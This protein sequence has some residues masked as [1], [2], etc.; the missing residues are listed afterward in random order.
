MS[1]DSML[2]TLM[3]IKEHVANIVVAESSFEC[4]ESSQKIVGDIYMIMQPRGSSEPMN[5]NLTQE[6]CLT[7]KSIFL[8]LLQALR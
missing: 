7:V 3:E 1:N 8:T 2:Q 6:I 5:E 4:R